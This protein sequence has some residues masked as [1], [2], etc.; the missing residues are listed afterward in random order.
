MPKKR[1]MKKAL[2]ET[3]IE[4]ALVEYVGLYGLTKKASVALGYS[5]ADGPIKLATQGDI[6]K[7]EVRLPTQE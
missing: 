1:L 7:T 3:L 6:P 5:N 2:R 4:E